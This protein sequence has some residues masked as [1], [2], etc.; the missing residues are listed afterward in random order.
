MDLLGTLA[1][2][3]C[4]IFMAALVAYRLRTPRSERLRQEIRDEFSDAD[5]R[6]AS[7]L[8]NHAQRITETEA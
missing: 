8:N 4:L 5:S 7:I 2:G 6:L 3:I 1:V